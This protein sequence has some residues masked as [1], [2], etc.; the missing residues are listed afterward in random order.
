[1]T[2]E[3][4]EAL[5]GGV[6][7]A[8]A[9]VRVGN[10][11]LRPA[12]ADTPRIH[13]LL[14]YVRAAGFTRVPEPVGID[15]DGRE[16]LVYIE[17]D[18]ACPPFPAWSQTEEWLVSTTELIRG[19]HDASVGFV[20]TCGGPWTTELA[21]PQGGSTVCHNDVCPENV[22]VRDGRAVAILDFEYAAPGRPVFDL[23][24]F[25]RMCVPLDT[26]EDAAL[27]GR[28]GLDPF[29]RL[30]IVADAYPLD[31]DGR[32]ELVDVLSEQ[33]ARGGE[34][35]RRRVEAGDEAFTKMWN[36][37]G[38]APRYERRRVWFEANRDR[39]MDALG[40]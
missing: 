39:F 25:A 23:A 34:F 17:G 9:V 16:R 29:A 15:P 1:M 35:V 24:S 21:D 26:E 30:A 11:V 12:T 5:A 37:T 10:H 4:E 22:V 32:R 40:A 33:M 31:A 3:D 7:N 20:E 28:G 6:A 14:S 18:I 13:A 2:G 27:L 38:G 36:E 19:L 8:G